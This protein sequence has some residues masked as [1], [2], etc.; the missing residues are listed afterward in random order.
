DVTPSN[1]LTRFAAPRTGKTLYRL[2]AGVY[3]EFYWPVN[4]TDYDIAIIP[5]NRNNPP[6]MRGF[7]MGAPNDPAKN[8]Y[9]H[10][11]SVARGTNFTKKVIVDVIN[12]KAVKFT[13]T[14]GVSIISGEHAMPDAATKGGLGWRVYRVVPSHPSGNLVGAAEAAGYF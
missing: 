12:F 1:H 5:Q 14:N 4:V 10:L 8:S 11:G 6:T 13:S 2:A 9:S 7:R 3:N